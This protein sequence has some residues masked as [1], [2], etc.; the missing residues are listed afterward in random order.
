MR[1]HPGWF[2]NADVR[3]VKFTNVEW[4]GMP[5]GIAG[6]LDEEIDALTKRTQ[7]CA[8]QIAPQ[9]LLAPYPASA[10]LSEALG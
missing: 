3:K 5:G 1:L 9:L 10:S 4:Y 8:H 6:T 7:T 2:I